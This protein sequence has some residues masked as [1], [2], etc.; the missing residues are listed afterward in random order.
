MYGGLDIHNLLVNLEQAFLIIR[1]HSLK[2]N[3]AKCAFG[4]LVGNFLSFLVRQRG[5]EVDKNKV[6]A[7]LEARP[8]MN[9]E[10]LP[11]IVKSWPF[12]G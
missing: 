11:A 9:K 8:P 4:V 6:K 10:E 1:Q 5:I 7:M 12:R 2:M 3:P